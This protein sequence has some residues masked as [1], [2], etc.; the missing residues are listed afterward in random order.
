MKTRT[1]LLIVFLMLI[2]IFAAVNWAEFTRP[3]ELSLLV[4]TVQAPLGLVM[5]GLTVLLTGVF[6]AYAL[7]LQT[8]ML[9]EARRHTKELHIQRELADHAEVSRITE[10]RNLMTAE[11]RNLMERS[12]DAQRATLDRIE[13]LERHL[14]SAFEESGNSVAATIGELDDRIVRQSGTSSSTAAMAPAQA[15]PMP[16]QRPDDAPLIR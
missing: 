3:A 5:L 4:T 7:Y 13:R 2:L 14:M 12:E 6:I 11:M 1:V 8:S 16:S 15:Q 10:M 9:L